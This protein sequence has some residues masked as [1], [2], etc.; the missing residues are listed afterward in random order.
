MF[1][2]AVSTISWLR[3]RSADVDMGLETKLPGS[4]ILNFGPCAER[5]HPNLA[6]SGEITHPERGAYVGAWFVTPKIIKI[7]NFAYRF[8]R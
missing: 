2:H 7:V 6:R 8:A 3:D 4:G 5:G 1:V